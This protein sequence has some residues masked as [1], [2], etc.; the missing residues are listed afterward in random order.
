MGYLYRHIRLDK[1]EPFYIGISNDKGYRAKDFKKR[2]KIWKNIYN[3]TNYEIEIL[4]ENLTWEQLCE[5]E[6]EFIKLYGRICDGTGTLSNL[7]MGGD[8]YLNPSLKER[9]KLSESKK[10]D[11]NPMYGKKFTQNHIENL[12]KARIGKIFSEETRKKI[13]QKKMNLKNIFLK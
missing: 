2:N 8:G 1:N 12:K 13:N 9:K 7:S 6:I 4:F 10:G 11:K 5:K 3:K